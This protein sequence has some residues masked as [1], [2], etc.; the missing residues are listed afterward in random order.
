MAPFWANL[1]AAGAVL[2]Y[3][4]KVEHI[5]AAHGWA[6]GVTTADGDTFGA[7]VVICNAAAPLLVDLLGEDVLPLEYV[8]RTT[9]P[10]VATSSITVYL[11]LDRDVFA[12]Q[13]LIQREIQFSVEGTYR[14]L[15]TFINFLEL[16][17]QFLTL[18]GVAL[19]EGG[20]DRLSIRLQLSTVFAAGAAEASDRGSE[21]GGSDETAAGPAAADA[22]GGAT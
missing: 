1:T 19:S 17:D 12:E 3:G 9:T 20:A 10:T 22:T 16:T 11:G 6:T 2:R 13:G 7:D 8:S 15:R 4:T 18:R 21:P 14:Q 5:G